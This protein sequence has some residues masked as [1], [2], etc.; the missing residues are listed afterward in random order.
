[1]KVLSQT[2]DTLENGLD[3]HVWLVELDD[4]TTIQATSRADN[5][6]T[7]DRVLSSVKTYINNIKT[8]K[9]SGDNR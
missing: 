1:M 9:G 6:F 4:N 5:P 8:L 7:E 2:K 3:V